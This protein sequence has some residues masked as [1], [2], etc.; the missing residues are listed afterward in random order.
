[1]PSQQPPPVDTNTTPNQG[2]PESEIRRGPVPLPA[3]IKVPPVPLSKIDREPAPVPGTT[4]TVVIPLSD[5]DTAPDPLPVTTEPTVIPLSDIDTAPGAV[6]EDPSVNQGVT[7]AEANLAL[8]SETVV[9]PPPLPSP[10]IRTGPVYLP[11]AQNGNVIVPR[12][13]LL[14]FLGNGVTVTSINGLVA[15]ITITGGGGGNADLGNWAFTANTMYNL[16]GGL[17]NNGDLSHGD[18]ARLSI[19]PNGSTDSILL[20]NTYGNIVLSSGVGAA[21]TASWTFD[22][23]GNLTLP[24][25]TFSVNFANG[26]PVTF[27][28]NTGNVTFSDQIVIGTGI[29]NVVGGLYLSPS[30]SGANALQYLRVRG[31]VSYEPTHIHFDTGNNLYFNQFIGD[32]NKYVLLSNTGNIVIRTDDYAGNSAQWDFGTDGNLTLPATTALVASNGIRLEANSDSNISGIQVYGDADANVYAHTNVVI[33]TDS[34]GTG[35]TWVFDNTGVL[36]VPASNSVPG[37]IST[38][39]TNVSQPGFDLRITAGNTN[40]CSVPGG[41]LYLSAGVGYNGVSHGAGNVNIVTGDRYGNVDGNIWRF[42]SNGTLTLPDNSSFQNFGSNSSEWHAGT[43][44]YVS[45]ASNDANTYMWVD[46]NG[47]Y[48]ATNWNPGA[49]QWTFDNTG[50]LTL[51]SNTFAVNYANGDPVTFGGGNA[52]LPLANGT[53][54]F[55]IATANGNV[56]ITANTSYTWAFDTDGTLT[57]PGNSLTIGN[58]LGAPSIIS[59]P[60]TPLQLVSSGNNANTV[61]GWL[62]NIETPTQLAVVVANNPFYVG[63]GDVGIVTGNSFNVEGGTGYIWNFDNAGNLILPRGGIVYETNIPGGTLAGNTIALKP[64][65]GIDADQQLLIYPTAIPGTDDNHLHLTSG[66]LYNTELFLG[67]DDLYVKLA[68]TGNVIVNSNDGAG[69]TA[70]WNFTVNGNLTLPGN[71]FAVNYANGDPVSLGGNYGD[72]NVVSLMGAFGSNTVFTT[73][74]ITAGNFV[75]SGS[76]IDIVAGSYDWTFDNSGNLTLPGNT[77]AVNYANGDPVTFGGG[78]ATLPLAN[79]TSNFDIATANGNVTVTTAGTN[80]WNFD[81]DG[82]LNLANNGVIRRDGAVNMVATGFAQLQWVDSGNI[83]IADPNVTGGPTN[84]AWV[85]DQGLWVQTNVN[86]GNNYYEWHFGTDGNLTTSSDMNIT[87]N[88]TGANVVSANTFVSNAFNV[89]TA[90]N[91]SITSQ[92]GLGVTG[93]ILEDNGTLELIAN[94]GGG[95]VLGWD[96]TYGNGLGNIAT[97]NFNEVNGG[98]GNIWLRTGNRSATEYIWNFD[99]TGNLTLPGNTFAVNYANGTQVP[100]GPSGSYGD[101]NVASFLANYGSNTISTTGNIQAGNISA[102]D[103]VIAT[104]NANVLTLTTRNG[105]SNNSY[106]IPQIIMGYAGTADYPSFIHTRHNAGTPVDNTIEFWTSDGTQAGTFPANAVLGLTVTNGNIET[107]NISAT[108]NITGGYIFGNGSQLTGVA[109]LSFTTVSANGT[110]VL[111][112]STT[113]TL[114]LT[115]GNNLVIT[116]NA[117]S[118]TVTFAVSDSPTF[119]GNVTGGN[120]LTGGVISS[121]GNI[122]GNY[123]LGNGSQ[124]TGVVTSANIFVTVSANGTSLVADQSSDTLTFASGNNIVIT[125]N[126]STDTATFAVSDSP[127]Y[128]GNVTGGNILTSGLISATGNIT[129]GNLSVTGNVTGNTAGFAIGYRDIPT[130]SLAANTTVSTSDAGKQ[131]YSTSASALT[132]TIA[133]NASQAFAT[134]ATINIINQGAGNVSVLRGVG[135]T[136]YLAGNSTSSDRTLTSYGVASVTKVASDTWFISGVGLI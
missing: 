78:N 3:P 135:V 28:A 127:T 12:T 73:G 55:D 133:N 21:V 104:G 89:V 6:T 83:N 62:D 8:P 53:S 70:Q 5:I 40:G 74:N 107:G 36:T 56:T 68:N 39:T 93:T 98:E 115:P 92:Y 124:L 34:N 61:L 17:I 76:N 118:D 50:N 69:N 132:L 84:W 75:G 108:G 99:S 105:D 88:I 65:G 24:D 26:T 11:V 16:N 58:A 95:V 37:Q 96:S 86:S 136:M 102:S 119:T 80:T 85:D 64:Q 110:S 33:H 57:F 63:E 52:T 117:T 13:A 41:D 129:G 130:L 46:N 114:T 134:G 44:G 111:A 103:N 27:S 42:D 97:V 48:I 47:A 128:T 20:Q 30:P 49:K 121:S 2:V 43:D 60:D 90:G 109:N 125:G 7:V 100:L 82:A 91:L 9:P 15:N 87:G 25:N 94:G 131:Y 101:S 81:I 32:D 72:S 22:G 66:N 51:P 113:D 120:I 77:F 18:T 35:H 23:T 4:T 79:G 106:V 123:I 29:S 1:M 45:L 31:D 67:S 71:T 122:T 10:T 54:N 14:N 38:Q 19:P 59:A 126:A 112:D 116:G